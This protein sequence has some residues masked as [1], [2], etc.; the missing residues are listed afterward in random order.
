M[1]KIVVILVLLIGYLSMFSQ[2][3]T[4]VVEQ[5]Q[6]SY[7][8]KWNMQVL[9][10]EV[11]IFYTKNI[12]EFQYK[13]ASV[14]VSWFDN[15]YDLSLD[16]GIELYKKKLQEQG[17][18]YR[19]LLLDSL[20]NFRKYSK[21]EYTGIQQKKYQSLEFYQEDAKIFIIE[22]S[23][24]PQND[25]MFWKDKNNFIFILPKEETIEKQDVEPTEIA[26]TTIVEPISVEEPSKETESEKEDSLQTKTDN[27]LLVKT[28]EVADVVDVTENN[29]ETDIC[30]ED[31]STIPSPKENPFAETIEEEPIMEYFQDTLPPIVEVKE[32][33][34]EPIATIAITEENI[35]TIEPQEEPSLTVVAEPIEEEPILEFFQDTLPPTV[36]VKEEEEEPIPTMEITEENIVTIEPIKEPSLT[37]VAE[38]IEEEPIL[39]YSQDTISSI[40]EIKDEEEETIPTIAITEENIVTIEPIK[41]PSIIFVAEKIEEEPILEYSQ[42]T[43][44]SIVEAIDIAEPIPTMDTTGESIVKVEPQEEL[45][46]TEVDNAEAE[47]QKSEEVAGKIGLC[48]NVTYFYPI[49]WELVSQRNVTPNT[50]EVILQSGKEEY[51]IIQ[52][53]ASF[54]EQSLLEKENLMVNNIKGIVFDTKIDSLQQNQHRFLYKKFYL[55]RLCGAL[56]LEQSESDAFLVTI[57]SFDTVDLTSS[58]YNYILNHLNENKPKAGSH[59]TEV[60][61]ISFVLPSG[62][63]VSDTIVEKEQTYFKILSPELGTA[64]ILFHVYDKDC[65]LV[66]LLNLHQMQQKNMF[67]A[68]EKIAVSKTAEVMMLYYTSSNEMATYGVTVCM[69]YKGKTFL[70]DV[71]TNALNDTFFDSNH[72]M[73]LLNSID[74]K[75]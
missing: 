32:E 6:F 30:D 25:Q 55:N 5:V 39:E 29:P 15:P 52:E 36:E 47:S 22:Q 69:R 63:M 16:F 54:T 10:P 34:E 24:I 53:D 17:I 35:V 4:R 68:F 11:N 70:I 31:T 73:N 27:E 46:F 37:V 45:N 57:Q 41:E 50:W 40:V 38:K 13:N 28:E 19:L 26:E 74:V 20:K 42:D 64:S 18:S 7:P 67:T 62:Y 51:I 23:E 48:S 43:V 2:N 61:D 71:F 44:P 9:E 8:K 65:N 58:S 3:L 33:E 49:D 56:V 75:S 12:V 1:K 72:L 59:R 66:R 14:K 60:G 21:V